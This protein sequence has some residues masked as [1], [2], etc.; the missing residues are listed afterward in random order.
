MKYDFTSIM[1][2]HGKDSIAVDGLGTNPGF[3]PE[4][5]GEGFGAIPMWV[6]DMNYATAP[7]IQKAVADRLAHPA[8]GYFNPSQAYYDSIIDWQ[9]GRHGVEGLTKEAIGYENGVLGCVASALDLKGKNGASPSGEIFLIKPVAGLPGQRWMVNRLYL[10]MSGQVI[11]NLK[12]I[13]YMPLH[14]QGKGL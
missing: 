2:R 1:D 4:P 11:R 13:A 8:F 9:A 3:T 10:G 6:A 5:P 7:S 14:T 12:G